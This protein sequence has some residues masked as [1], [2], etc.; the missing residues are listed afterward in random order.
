MVDGSL[1]TA[2]LTGDEVDDSR[3]PGPADPG[4]LRVFAGGAPSSGGARL[5]GGRA[6]VGRSPECT[7]RLD[8]ARV[9]RE[10]AE[11]TFAD[12]RWTVRDLGSHNGSSL[13]GSSVKGGAVVG[14]RGVVRVGETV[15]LLRRNIG[16]Y[17]ADG[18]TAEGPVVAGP[19]LRA[20]W[21]AVAAAAASCEVLYLEGE[22]GSGKELAA[23]RFHDCGPRPSG[24][25]VAVN[26]AAIPPLLAERLLFGALRG[27]YSGA[28][29]SSEGYVTSADG[30]TLFLDEVADLPAEVQG[31][32]LRALEAGEVL[33]LGASRARP[34]KVRFCSAGHVD[35]RARVAAGA[36]R[37]DLFYRLGRPSVRVPPLR[38]RP[39]EIPPLIMRALGTGPAAPAVTAAFVEAVMLRQ[40][41]GNLRELAKEVRAAAARAA[42]E[43]ARVTPRHLGESA[44]MAIATPAAAPA[45]AAAAPAPHKLERAEVLAALQRERGSVAS[46]ARALGVRRTTFRRWLEKNGID[47][48]QFAG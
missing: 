14:A 26:C 46:T 47:P 2:D 28:D 30:G 25:F 33:P 12:E 35:L 15:L 16:P 29:A 36:F 7:L 18:V 24:P 34:V 44:G 5:S 48:K 23:R 8:D 27:A 19:P 3:G 41:P 40:W 22:S 45:A 32:L 9:S 37:E 38:D 1:D 4:I 31:K 43:G 10:H 13:D 17:L 6:T 20:A 42:Q 11:I 39:E 21:R